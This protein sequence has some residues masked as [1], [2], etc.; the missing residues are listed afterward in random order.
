VQRAGEERGRPTAEGVGVGTAVRWG[1]RVCLGAHDGP[2]VNLVEPLSGR[3]AADQSGDE[4]RLDEHL[5]C[6]GERRDADHLK[7]LEIK[8]GVGGCLP[9]EETVHARV[10]LQ[11]WVGGWGGDEREAWVTA[12]EI[13]L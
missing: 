8:D 9:L 6:A 1:P 11:W 3:L 2:L 13:A 5:V 7:R 12:R 10:L 4:G